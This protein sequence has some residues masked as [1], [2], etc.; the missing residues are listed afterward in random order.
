VAAAHSAGSGA[1]CPRYRACRGRH[2]SFEKFKNFDGRRW[3]ELLQQSA[4]RQKSKRLFQFTAAISPATP[5]SGRANLIT[6]GLEKV[7]SLNRANILEISAPASKGIIVTN[8][9]YGVRLGEQQA[10]AEFYQARRP[11]KNNS[12]AWRAYPSAPTCDC[13]AHPPRRIPSARR[14]TTAPRMPTIRIQDGRKEE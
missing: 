11:I 3:R 9:P 1:N 6:A 2:F 10:L 8:P 7:V 12:A 5:E 14:S 13:Q 4:G